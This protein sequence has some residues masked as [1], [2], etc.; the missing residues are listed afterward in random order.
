MPDKIPTYRP[1]GA[2]QARDI[3]RRQHDR[4]RA[5]AESRRLRGKRVYRDRFVPMILAERPTCEEC[6]RVSS[7]VVHHIRKLA[8]H[9]EDLLDPEH[10]AALCKPCHDRITGEGG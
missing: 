9:P 5:D 2:D 6:G 8:D 4:Q 10:V 7:A 3:C 1:P